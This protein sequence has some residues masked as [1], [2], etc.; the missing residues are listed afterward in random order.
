MKD[1]EFRLMRGEPF[2]GIL[3]RSGWKDFEE[4]TSAIMKEAG[5]LTFR[6]FRFSS[7]RKRY[8]IDVI[9]LENPRIILVDCKRWELRRGK[10]SALKTSAL[11]HLNRSLEF[12]GKVQEFKALN[13]INWKTVIVI[14]IIVTLYEEGIVEYEKV[15][16]VPLFKMKSFLEGLRSGLFDQFSGQVLNLER[17]R[18]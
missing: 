6:N 10:T 18:D 1:L 2:E 13:V 3:K 15:L 14:P 7:R 17:W 12:L 8:E 11:R 4:L 16:I 5:F 9:A